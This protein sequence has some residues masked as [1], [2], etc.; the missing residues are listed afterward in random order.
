MPES[1]NKPT[2]TTLT[3]I[4][5]AFAAY[6]AIPAALFY[7]VGFLSRWLQI[8]YPYDIKIQT[9][10]H[11]TAVIDKLDVVGQGALVLVPPLVL[12]ILLS[13]LLGNII[14]LRKG[15]SNRSQ[16]QSRWRLVVWL[17]VWLVG[18]VFW[19]LSLNS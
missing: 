12:S 10:W 11:A 13:L 4:A 8:Y 18:V 15:N 16:G 17:V 5:T 1:D 19:R 6:V 2:I 14:Y 9:A 7:P 3:D